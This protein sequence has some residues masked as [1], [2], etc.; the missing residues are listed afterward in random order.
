MPPDAAAVLAE[1]LG[2]AE[3]PE[4]ERGEIL[5]AFSEVALKGALAAILDKLP[6]AKREEF[7]TLAEGGDAAAIKAFLDREVPDH[8]QLAGT[9]IREELAAFTKSVTSNQPS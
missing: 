9:A 6:P 4:A 2:V 8:E 5:D 7:A 3:L 1:K